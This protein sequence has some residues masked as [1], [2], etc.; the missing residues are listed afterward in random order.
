MT[1]S[2]QLVIDTNIVIKQFIDDPL[3]EKTH[4]LFAHLE[5]DPSTQFFV[6]DLLYIECANVLLKY[7]RAG[8]Y[9]ID[10]IEADLADL[11]TLR[12]AVAPTKTL[13]AQ[14]VQISLRYG[15]SA[16]DGSYVALSLQAE[17]PLL[18][19][20]KRLFNSL[21]NS[22]FDVRLFTNFEIPPSI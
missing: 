6:P 15:I 20:D 9:P 17:V 1:D 4:Q 21:A 3:A 22:P 14:A 12:L 11:R 7:V 13:I 8:L 5:Q 2:L 10:S 19:L 16:Y 18:T